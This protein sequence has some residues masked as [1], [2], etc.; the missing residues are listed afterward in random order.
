M[1]GRLNFEIDTELEPGLITSRAGVP[2]L[3]E[4]YRLSGRAAVVERTVMLKQR[5]RGPSSSEMVESFLALWAAGG[6]RA[7][8]SIS[9]VKTRHWPS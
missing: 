5:K 6:E 4:V 2:S 7:R 8:T 9:F 1:T 3:V